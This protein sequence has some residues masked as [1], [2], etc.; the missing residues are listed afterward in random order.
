MD[1][2]VHSAGIFPMTGQ[3]PLEGKRL[4]ALLLVDDQKQHL[5][6]IMDIGT[7]VL[8]FSSAA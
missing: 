4:S 8:T 7:L 1:V 5:I 3:T 2:V 6:Q